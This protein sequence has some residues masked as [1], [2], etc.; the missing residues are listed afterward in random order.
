MNNVERVE[1][2]DGLMT[3]ELENSRGEIETLESLDS[4]HKEFTE[5]AAKLR[6]IFMFHMTMPE[7]LRSRLHVTGIKRKETKDDT[8]FIIMASIECRRGGMNAEM[9]V[10]SGFLRR[11]PYRFFEILDKDGN[12]AY[13]RELHLST[14]SEQEVLQCEMV[15]KEAWLYAKEGK[16]YRLQHDLLEATAQEDKE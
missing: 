6:D 9:P 1:W 4:P 15:M 3:V 16:R 7:E 12:P 10:K 11:P 13:P 2:K 8:G 14:L 5:A